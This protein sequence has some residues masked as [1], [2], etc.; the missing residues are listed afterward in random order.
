M[1]MELSPISS[2]LM[3]EGE[4]GSYYS[5]SSPVLGDAKV[6]AGVLVLKPG[7]FALPHYADCSKVGYVLQGEVG[8]AA[9]VSPNGDKTEETVLGLEAGDVI[10]VPSGSTSWW[11]NHGNSS[12]DIII[13]FLGETANAYIPGQFTYFF[14][15]GAR[16][17]LAGFSTEIITRAYNINQE[18]ANI[19][20]KTRTGFLIVKLDPDQT[21][22]IPQPHQNI[23]NNWLKNITKHLPDIRVDKAGILCCKREWSCSNCGLNSKLVLDSKIVVGQ[24][25]VVPR[26]FTVAII[27]QAQGMEC[28]S[29]TTSSR[30]VEVADFASN[31]S[32]LNALSPSILRCALNVPPEFVN[33]FKG[34][35][36][37]TDV[38]IPPMS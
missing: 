10:P 24:L 35:M 22:N 17:I 37:K 7:G 6:G 4:G 38:L 34:Q 11:Y 23:V 33:F 15:T 2:K 29:I 27:A 26:F 25:V 36:A 14:L 21:K 18:Q 28:F 9:L 19:L 16:G 20:A 8:V 13:V 12:V 30:P 1:D 5:W 31:R 32:V 3:F